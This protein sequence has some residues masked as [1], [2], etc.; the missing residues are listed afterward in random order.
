VKIILLKRI[1][2]I[3]VKTIVLVVVILAKMLIVVNAILMKNGD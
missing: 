1:G 2:V 3:A